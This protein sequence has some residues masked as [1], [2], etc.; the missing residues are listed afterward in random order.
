[1]CPPA[2]ATAEAV[3]AGGSISEMLPEDHGCILCG[4]TAYAV[5]GGRKRPWLVRCTNCALARVHPQPSD[6][7]LSRIYGD[8]YFEQFGYS[9]GSQEAYRQMKQ[10]WCRR[11]LTTAETHFPRGTVLDVGSGLGDFLV[12][13]RSRE[14]NAVGIEP[15][16]TAVAEADKI[17]TGS[18]RN[19]RIEEFDAMGR[20]WDLVVCL[21]VL[22]H[23]R[24]P[25][26]CLRRMYELVRPGGGL[27]LATVDE[28]SWHARICGTR[29]VHY[30]RDHLWYFN[31][32]TLT[33]LVETTGFEV[34]R[35]EV[36]R[37]RFNLRYVLGILANHTRV[38]LWK[39]VLEGGLRWLPD[40]IL[41]ALL[42]PIPEGQLVLARK[43]EDSIVVPTN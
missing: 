20:K 10:A 4:A 36:P 37:K 5:I 25:D 35:W 38:P 1:M 15:N 40:P 3:L 14:W 23:L 16:H 42:P 31:R 19:V 39:R 41:S 18:T 6:T 29:W 34:L 27:L 32:Q 28:G 8:E 30:H 9:L 2:F 7:E 12:A 21:D 26:C 13:A 24:R 17:V 11:L 22:E 33:K 43:P